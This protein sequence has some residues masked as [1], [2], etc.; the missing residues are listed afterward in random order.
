VDGRRAVVGE[1]VDAGAADITIRTAVQVMRISFD[2]IAS[3]EF[4]VGRSRH[5][6]EGAAGFSVVGAVVGLFMGPRGLS[7]PVPARDPSTCPLQPN[8]NPQCA[9]R[10]R[11]RLSPVGAG[12][13]AVIG[14]GVGLVVGTLVNADKWRGLSLD[15]LPR[16]VSLLAPQPGARRLGI[17]IAF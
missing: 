12:Y 1:F 15:A 4:S 10:S 7:V 11:A 5:P 13:G 6:V 2:S 9:Y 16:H 3:L 8:T 17:S 14:A